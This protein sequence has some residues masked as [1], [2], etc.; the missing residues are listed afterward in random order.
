MG[1]IGI[2]IIVASVVYVAI[3]P[4]PWLFG[5]FASMREW[6]R[7]LLGFEGEARQQQVRR[8]E[9]DDG[10]KMTTPKVKVEEASI[11]MEEVSI[12]VEEV[13]IVVEDTAEKDAAR[14]APTRGGGDLDDDS[15]PDVPPPIPP[16]APRNQPVPD[17][18]PPIP[19]RAPRDYSEKVA[20]DRLA[21]P[22]PPPPPPRI[23]APTLHAPIVTTGDDDTDD[24]APG[25]GAST[26]KAQRPPV[27]SFSPPT[28][29][30]PSFPAANSAQRTR[31][32]PLPNRGG[33][34]S[35]SSSSSSLTP[36][37][38]HSAP[39][40][41]PSRA[42]VLT[43]GHSPLDWARIAENPTA[44]L[45]GL[46][47][48]APATL[49]KI[50]PSLL[51]KMTGRKGKDAWMAIGGRVYNVSPYADFHPG[52]KGELMRGAGRDATQLF[53]EVHPWVNYEGML[54]SCLI[55][56]LVGE[57]DVSTMDEMD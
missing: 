10:N 34:A 44:D 50:P 15:I 36:P 31:P 16:R 57:S 52:G 2:T 39:P 6:S 17:V 28:L 33:P 24:D 51:R 21:M 5:L 19:P 48:D 22:P 27:P 12:V 43:P 32:S 25:S 26:P 38:T 55:G 1:V 49:L 9:E 14:S 3:R 8:I 45:R 30:P 18:P 20:K 47:P 37:P 42:V 11:V 40:T 35:S 7:R 29:A 53:G 4:Q 54:R 56:I 23:A 46:G 41:K 13:S